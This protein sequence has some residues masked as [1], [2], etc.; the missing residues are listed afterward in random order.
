[1]LITSYDYAHKIVEQNSNLKW[2]GWDIVEYKKSDAA[3]F[4]NNG[5]IVDGQWYATKTFTLTESGWEVP[6]KYARP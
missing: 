4:N 6:N 1:M 2:D 5:R 3:E